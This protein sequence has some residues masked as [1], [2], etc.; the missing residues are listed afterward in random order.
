MKDLVLSYLL[1]YSQSIN[2]IQQQRITLPVIKLQDYVNCDIFK[3]FIV[4][5]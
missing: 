4:L 3:T 5:L 2:T 1:Q